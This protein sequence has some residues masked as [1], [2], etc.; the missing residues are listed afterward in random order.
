M[1]LNIEWFQRRT[2]TLACLFL[3]FA[4][5]PVFACSCAPPPPPLQELLN[6]DFVFSGT[7]IEMQVLD[8]ELPWPALIIAAT[9]RV[10][11][12]FKGQAGAEI[13]AHTPKG[14]DSCGFHFE[15]GESYLVYA[16]RNEEK[17]FT[18][19]C[20]RTRR[21]SEAGEDVQQLTVEAGTDSHWI[22]LRDRLGRSKIHL[23]GVRNKP[24]TIEASTDF[25]SW[26]VVAEIPAAASYV[27]IEPENLSDFPS[28]YY[29]ARTESRSPEG[30]YGQV[31]AHPGVCLK[32]PDQPGQCLNLPFPG[33]GSYDVREHADQPDQG[34]SN[35]IV[36]SF[37]SSNDGETETLELGSEYVDA[38]NEQRLPE[39]LWIEIAA[40]GFSL[41]HRTEVRAS[42]L[43]RSWIIH[44]SLTLR[45][46]VVRRENWNDAKLDR[47]YL[48]ESGTFQVPLPPGRYCIWE[49]ST[50]VAQVD[51]AAGEW[52]S[53]LLQQFLP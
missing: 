6:A 9:F 21:L 19:I 28:R 41:S 43:D 44:D 10:D 36:V 25:V 50:C 2:V 31:L 20:T 26:A 32:D 38:L 51:I 52:S 39:T 1:K 29:R 23:A 3:L 37:A 7:V 46:F 42:M 40:G 16:S 35:P 49:H 11:D 13:T 14:G 47:L 5:C 12:L 48:T 8:G 17:L 34:F 33:A 27:A 15:I 18:S 45:S 53:A 30:F 4:N 22:T 24:V